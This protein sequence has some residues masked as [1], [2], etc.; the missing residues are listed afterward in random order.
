VAAGCCRRDG[1]GSFPVAGC[2]AGV[3]T[4]FAQLLE[5]IGEVA[6]C[7]AAALGSTSQP[8]HAATR[9]LPCSP[10]RQTTSS[11]KQ[12]SGS[13]RMPRRKKST[14]RC[15]HV[16]SPANDANKMSA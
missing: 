2:T 10:R 4:L 11:I 5:G 7:L 13:H 16:S 12:D 14:N 6:P 1:R 15:R 3:V 8:L 9:Y